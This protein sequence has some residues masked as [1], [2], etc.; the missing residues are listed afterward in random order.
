MNKKEPLMI[1][2]GEP[3]RPE[4]WDE[5]QDLRRFWWII[6]PVFFVVLTTGVMLVL[7]AVAPTYSGKVH[8][9]ETYAEA[10]DPDAPLTVQVINPRG[11]IKVEPRDTDTV[12]I[13]VR[14]TAHSASERLAQADLDSMHAFVNTEP[15]KLT[16]IIAYATGRDGSAIADITLVVPLHARI[17]V[18]TLVGNIEIEMADEGDYRAG[19]LN[20]DIKI[21]LA[22]EQGAHIAAVAKAVYANFSLSRLATDGDIATYRTAPERDPRLFLDL[23]A[24]SG[25]ITL[26]SR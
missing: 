23:R 9:T 18:E 8:S 26:R 25:N 19:T 1:G 17:D 20:G 16:L 22:P 12:S 24:P 6:P 15:G 13:E 4:S 7:E 21:A 3:P 2:D 11:S 14:K 5:A 10:V